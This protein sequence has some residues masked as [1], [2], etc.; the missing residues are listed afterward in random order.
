MHYVLTTAGPMRL[1]IHDVMGRRVAS[2][3][4][5]TEEA[6]AHSATWE[7]RDARGSRAPAGVY[8]ARLESAG[9]AVASK[10]VRR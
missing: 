8:W 10:I 5:R 4:D 3:A 1:T 9:E 6:G 7:G 2:L